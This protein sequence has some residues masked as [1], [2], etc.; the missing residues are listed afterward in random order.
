M[1]GETDRLM[2][3]TP[4]SSSPQPV[5]L[6]VKNL[7]YSIKGTPILHNLNCKFVPNKL[8]A[9]MGPSGA[10]KTTLMNVMCG[11]AGGKVSGQVLVN[12]ARMV[13]RQFKMIYKFVPQGILRHAPHSSHYVNAWY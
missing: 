9:L 2:R 6:T 10:G 1:S 11:R 8:Y 12:N 3:S 7:S 13:P 5:Q 4:P